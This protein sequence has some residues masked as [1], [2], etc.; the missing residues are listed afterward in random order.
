MAATE[1]TNCGA[2]GSV[3]EC[4]GRLIYQRTKRPTAQMNVC[5]AAEKTAD[6]E[7]KELIEIKL[8]LVCA[9]HNHSC[10]CPDAAAL[11]RWK[12]TRVSEATV[13]SL[14]TQSAKIR[15]NCV[16]DALK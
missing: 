2:S 3:A 6:E 9:T 11:Q 4:G 16:I 8:R 1:R 12:E 10:C 7:N 13:S 5:A 14:E 15:R